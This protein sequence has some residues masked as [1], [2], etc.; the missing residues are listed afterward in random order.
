M[1][2]QMEETPKA[3]Y[4]WGWWSEL[5]CRLCVYRLPHLH[6]FSSPKALRPLFFG[7]FWRLHYMG[8]IDSHWPL[9]IDSTSSPSLFPGS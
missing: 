7:V 4:G 2:I 5:A 9:V 1:S 3:M 6:V 8:I